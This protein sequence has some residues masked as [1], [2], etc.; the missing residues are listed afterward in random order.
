[1]SLGAFADLSQCNV[2]RFRK[3]R[4]DAQKPVSHPHFSDLFTHVLTTAVL[5]L[6]HRLGHR[7]YVPKAD[8]WRQS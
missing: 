5:R 7:V 1:M 8:R 3:T 6:L 4:C 2:C